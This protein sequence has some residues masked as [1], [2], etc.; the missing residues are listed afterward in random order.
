MPLNRAAHADDP[1]AFAATTMDADIADAAGSYGLLGRYRL[2]RM[3][4]HGAMGAVFEAFDTTL[5]RTVAIKTLHS[6]EAIGPDE[7]DSTVNKAAILQEARAAAT[8][9]HPNIVTVYDAGYALSSSLKRELPFVAMELLQGEDLRT[10]QMHTPL[11]Q[12][13]AVALIGKLAL[14]LDHAH[15]TGVLHRDIKPG[16]IFVTLNGTPKILDFG[17]AKLSANT[18]SKNTSQVASLQV[19]HQA[20]GLDALQA[21]S[22]YYMSPEQA[23]GGVVDARTDVYALGAVLFELLTGQVPLNAPTLDLLLTRIAHT[24][25]PVPHSINMAVPVELSDIVMRALAKKPDDRYR[26]AS[27]FAQ[28]LR[29]WG[30]Q[31]A[32]LEA[33][34]PTNTAPAP[35]GAANPPD[36]RTTQKAGSKKIALIAGL[37]ALACAALL[38]VVLGRSGAPA[39]ASASASANSPSQLEPN[40][41]STASPAITPPA[42]PAVPAV[43]AVSP[44]S[45]LPATEPVALPSP[46]STPAPTSVSAPASTQLAQ[47]ATPA[48]P[49]LPETALP[50][51]IAQSPPLAALT[52]P[53]PA[54][55]ALGKLRL[56]ITPW[57]SIEVNGKAMGVSPPLTTLSL[58]PGDHTIVVRNADFA[59]RSFRI[60]LD[61]DKTLRI[62]HNFDKP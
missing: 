14:A 38:A 9:N 10:R 8:L 19:K 32:G 45:T 62:A 21:G 59:P 28:K 35:L 42:L 18:S 1:S 55:N 51:V 46:T 13:D 41:P 52:A 15:Q 5:A 27:H 58:P 36:S 31:S 24:K 43:A 54:T 39:P 30:A 3:V 2:D 60:K 47:P 48:S 33:A 11:S 37:A 23:A 20:T 40:K 50:T 22:P 56:A 17:L 61:A 16:N 26:S 6:A 29:R 7:L 44:A 25:P 49:A 34:E 57:G 12:R 4:G 53:E